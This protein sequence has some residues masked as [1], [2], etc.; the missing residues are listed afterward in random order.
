MNWWNSTAS[1]DC[2]QDERLSASIACCITLRTSS[3]LQSHSGLP[4]SGSL[5]CTPEFG[6]VTGVQKRPRQT[7]KAAVAGFPGTRPKARL[8]SSGS[9]AIACR[10]VLMSVLPS[11]RSKKKPPPLR[12]SNH[13]DRRLSRMRTTFADQRLAVR[14]SGGEVVKHGLERDRRLK[15]QRF[16]NVLARRPLGAPVARRSSICRHREFPGTGAL[17]LTWPVSC[18]ILRHWK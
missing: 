13:S 4:V 10:P 11:G 8:L 16:E 2:L 18:R 7:A 14:I 17:P 12:R 3:P 15:R 6:S 1:T 9:R 5:C